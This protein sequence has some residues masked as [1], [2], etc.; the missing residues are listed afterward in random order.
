MSDAS[1]PGQ[2]VDLPEGIAQEDG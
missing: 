1:P 2:P